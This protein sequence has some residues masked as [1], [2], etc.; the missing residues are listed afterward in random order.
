M[1]EVVIAGVGQT[2]VGEHW[3]ISLRELAFYA[4][5]AAREDAGGLMP[6]ALYLGNMLAPALSHQSH[7][8]TLLADFAG[9]QGIEA[10]MI[11]AAGASGGAALRVGYLAV[12]SDAVNAALVVGVEKMSDQTVSN[13]HAAEAT[14]TTRSVVRSSTS[15]R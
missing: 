3:D 4:T 6:Q 2:S 15:P 14:T 10:S 11:E 8:A 12:A 9:L 7:L 13:V 5:E 1:H